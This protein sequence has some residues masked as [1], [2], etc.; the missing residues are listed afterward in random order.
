MRRT[1]ILVL[2]AIAL[3]SS[4]G[5]RYHFKTTIVDSRGMTMA[6]AGQVWADGVRYR[7]EPDPE[8]GLPPG[9]TLLSLDSDTT[10]I[11]LN[12]EK[13]TWYGRLRPT[14]KVRSS[15]MFDLPIGGG[16]LRRGWSVTLR[17]DGSSTI[18]GRPARKRIMEVEYDLT[19]HVYR[20][21][22]RGHFVATV[23]MWHAEDLPRLPL[24]RPFKTGFAPIDARIEELTKGIPGM[25]L[26]HHLRITRTLE[27]GEGFSESVSTIVDSVEQTDIP[28]SMFEVPATF[29]F[30]AAKKPDIV[31]PQ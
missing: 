6:T 12:P 16:E 18:A 21:P 24:D 1:L 30:E 25:T 22:V 31:P 7:F 11:H 15:M 23:E 5:V 13:R 28:S 4:A 8:K 2:L 17:D 10:M 29:T 3:P 27:G 9:E 14:E 20:A 26:R 19:Y